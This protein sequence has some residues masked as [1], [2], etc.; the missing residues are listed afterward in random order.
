MVNKQEIADSLQISI[1]SLLDAIRY[2]RLT[3][4]IDDAAVLVDG[5]TAT[6]V[7][8]AAPYACKVTEVTVRAETL[9]TADGSI[10]VKKAASGTAISGGTAVITQVIPTTGGG[11]VA[12][13][14][15]ACTIV[16]AA[17]ANQMAAGDVLAIVVGTVGEMTGLQYNVVIERLN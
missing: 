7:V 3:G 17:N 9:E 4:T 10:D 2:I 1:N 11:M 14:N 5:G 12:A 13:T 8:F 6:V 15:Y 16:T